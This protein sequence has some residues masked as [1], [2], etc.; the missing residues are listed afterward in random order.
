MSDRVLG[1]VALGLYV[2]YIALAFGLRTVVHRRAT[3]SAGFR[4]ISGRPGSAEWFA[5]VSF[6][7]AMIAGVVAP[8]AQLLGAVG[9]VG[10]LAGWVVHLVGGVVA[11]AGIVA[12]VAA[13]NAMGTSWRVGVDPG[14]RTTLVTAGPF[15]S[16]RNPIFTAMVTAAA[17]LTL[18]A[19]NVVA[20][21]GLATLALAVQL[22]VRVV[23]EPYL[24]RVHGED[25]ARY[26]AAAGR[27]LPRVG[28]EPTRT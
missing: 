16:V 24:R 7:V 21:A 14:E 1:A 28:R 20:I 19:P 4:G 18:L 5:G 9:P 12:T 13:Q 10:P 6:V 22:Q 23:E 8:V 11:V 2:L 25:Y 3:G 15:A 26:T 17:G 27:F